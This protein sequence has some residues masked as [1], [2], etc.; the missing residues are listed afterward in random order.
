MLLFSHLKTKFSFIPK[1]MLHQLR[2]SMLFC[3][4][5]FHVFSWNLGHLLWNH[6]V[7]HEMLV[8]R[9]VT[10]L[11]PKSLHCTTVQS[12]YCLPSGNFYHYP[13]RNLVEKMKWI[14]LLTSS[15]LPSFLLPYNYHISIPELKPTFGYCEFKKNILFKFKWLSYLID[16][17]VFVSFTHRS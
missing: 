4:N 5:R 9:M 10:G 1:I 8:R 7:I 12:T 15:A 11:H 16:T 13:N 2:S 6:C 17:Y 3:W 14:L